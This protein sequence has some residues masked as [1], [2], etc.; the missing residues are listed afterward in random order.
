M[1]SC[2]TFGP[3]FVTNF[4]GNSIVKIDNKICKKVLGKGCQQY[5]NL[6]FVLQF[7]SILPIQPWIY[8]FSNLR[9]QTLKKW[10]NHKISTL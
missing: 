5:F 10:L 2:G 1:V 6:C 4:P 9:L 3:R 7:L 8:L